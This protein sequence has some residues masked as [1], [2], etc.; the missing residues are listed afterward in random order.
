MYWRKMTRLQFVA[1]HQMN[2][3]VRVHEE[4]IPSS[5]LRVS[6]C[7]LR[8]AALTSLTDC[9]PTLDSVE[10]G[11]LSSFHADFFPSMSTPPDPHPPVIR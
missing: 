3:P 4:S 6:Q 9:L 2:I 5:T 1:F 11:P 8:S 7:A 10:T